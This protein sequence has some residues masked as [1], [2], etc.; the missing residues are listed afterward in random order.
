MKEEFEEE[1]KGLSPFLHNLKKDSKKE[2]V[3]KVP[4]N[5]FDTLADTIIEKAQAQEKQSYPLSK[6]A[7]QQAPSVAKPHFLEQVKE[8]IESLLQPRYALGFATALVIVV[9][10]W[11]FVNYRNSTLPAESEMAQ[12]SH[13]EIHQYITENIDDFDEELIL[14]NQE[15][16]DNEGDI[17]KDINISDDE[18]QK[19]LDENFD[20]KDIKEL[21]N[22][23]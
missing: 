22:K 9:A 13:E 10:G 1:L 19:Y 21:E 14:K 15:L 11:W 20:E 5:Y 3:F 16:A 7:I 12:L 23:L 2:D 4:Q 8:W 17:N 18:L 6:K